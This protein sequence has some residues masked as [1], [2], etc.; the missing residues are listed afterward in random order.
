MVDTAQRL[1]NLSPAQRK[2][3]EKRLKDQP[4]MAQPIAVVGMACRLPGAPNLAA[5]WN[6]ISHQQSTIREVPP[7]RWDA[8]E[9]YDPDPD[10]PG[11][12]PTKWF[13]MVDEV[14]DFDP[15]FF[16]IS[17]REAARM[18]PQQRLLLEVTWEALENANIAPERVAGS[19]TGVFVGIGGTDYSKVATQLPNYFELMDPHV[20]TGNALSIAAN[21]ISY[22]FDLKGPSFAVDTAC[23]SGSVGLHLAVQ[24]LRNHECD[25]ALSGAVNLILTPEVSIAFSKARMLSPTGQCRPFDAEANGYVRGEGGI[26]LV[27]KRL[28]DATRDGDNILAVI[29]GT[30]INQDGRTSGITAPNALSQQA[31]IRA[32]LASAGLSLDDVSYVEAHGTGTPLGDPIEFQSLS[33]LF[34][35]RDSNAPKCYVGS[36]KANIGHT[37]TV[38][39]LAG[40]VKTILMM[41]HRTIPGQALLENLNPN[42][43]LSNT[44]LEIPR[45]N[46]DWD[47]SGKMV[48]GV[49]SFGFGGTNAHIVVE[50]AAVPVSETP[51]DGDG[52]AEG[53]RLQTRPADVLCLSAKTDS[54]VRQLASEYAD[55]LA[56]LSPAEYRSF[57]H[58]ANVGRSHFNRRVAMVTHS[59]EELLQQLRGVA[60]GKKPAGTKAAEVKIAMKPKVGFLFTG[61]GAQYA[62]M[63]KS[64][65][66]QHPVF[67]EQLDRCNEILLG[68]RDQSLLSVI[69]PAG[70]DTGL[71]NETEY[72]QPA[73]FAIEYALAV[74]WRSWG[75]E[76]SV[77]LGHSVG[78]YVAA[79]IAGVFSLEDG[80]RLIAKRA[81]LMQTLPR[82]GSMA[83]IFARREQVEEAI[84]KYGTRVAVATANGPENNVISGETELVNEVVAAFAKQGIGTQQL[85]V[86]HAFHSPL[87]DPILDQFEAFAS[88]LTYD[89]PRIPIVS[90]RTGQLVETAEFDAAYWRDHLRNAVEFAQGM[91]TLSQQTLHALIEIGPTASLL[92]MGKRCTPDWEIAWIPS[93][94]KGRND[95]DTLLS[96][97]TDIYLLGWKIDWK[98]F[99]ASW[100]VGHAQLPTYPFERIRCWYDVSSP[101][102]SGFGGARGPSIHPLLG[103]RVVTAREG[104]L[105]E[106]RFSSDSPKYLKD[107]QVQGSVVVPAAAYIEQG[108]AVARMLFGEGAHGVQNLSIQH[109][110]FLPV[111]GHRIVEVTATPEMSGQSTFETFSIP[112]DTENPNVRWELHASGAAVHQDAQPALEQADLDLHSFEDRV[113]KRQTR[114]EFYELMSAR[115]LA[116]GP[117]F[118]V[119]GS[120]DRS[121][122]DALS[123]VQLPEFVERELDKY[124]L[125][126]SLG[127]AML[128]T[129]AGIVP[130]EENGDYT[131][132]TYMP[133]GVRSVHVLKPLASTMR[134]YAIRTSTVSTPSPEMVEG[135]LYLIDDE[136]QIVVA[137]TGVSVRRVGRHVGAAG[138]E[139]IEDWLYRI[140]WNKSPLDV[141]TSNTAVSGNYLLLA[142]Q[143]G[144]AQSLA[145]QLGAAGGKCVVVRHGAE[146]AGDAAT[147]FTVNPTCN[148]QIA[149]LLQQALGS[150]SPECAGIIHC[151]SLDAATA[152]DASYDWRAARDLTTAS[153]L[154]WLQQAAKYPFKQPPAVWLVTQGAQPV[155]AQPAALGFA[156]SPVWG[157]GRVAAMEH[158]ELKCRLVDLDP[159]ADIASQ[160]G[161][162]TQLLV[163]K[164][165]EDQIAVR[166]DEYFVGRLSPAPEHAGSG[167]AEGGGV[168]SEGP[169]RLR[170]TDTGSFDSLKYESFKRPA[171]GPGQVEIEVAATGLNFSD[172]LKAMGLYPGITDVVV[173]VG[174]ECSG[175]VTAVG[176]GVDR[177][178]VGDAVMGVAP[179]SFASHTVTA[180]Y[181]LVKKPDTID[182]QEAATVPITFLTAYYGLVRLAQMQPGE[183]V[184]I[185]AGAGGVGLAAIQI[186]QHLGA[187]VFATAGSD[188]KR[189]YL[190]SLGVKHVMNS[191]N[192]EFADQIRELTHREGIDI[193][194]NS[195]PGEA[196][197]KSLSVLRAYGRFLEIGK[198]DIY[199]N[200]MIGLLPFQDNLSYFAIDLDRMLRQRPTYIRD[201]FEEVMQFFAA[202]HFKALPFT[203]FSA[204][205]TV[206]AFRYMAQRKNI[207]KVVVSYE[208]CQASATAAGA[209][210]QT[211]IAVADGTYLITGGLGALGLQ[212]AEWLADHGAGAIALL[213]RRAPSGD[214][215]AMIASL[216]E[217]GVKTLAIQ[218]DVTE[219]NSLDSALKQ[220]PADYPPLRGVFHAAGVLQDGVLYDMD[221]DQ[222]DKPLGP[223]VQG[224]WN[225]HVA[226]QQAP[227]DHFV[228][229]SSIACVLGSPGQANYAA[230][231]AFLDTFAAY[232]RA[233]GL[234]ATSINWGPWADSGMAAEAGRDAQL[235]SRGMSLLPSA[236]AL[237]AMEALLKAGRTQTAVMSVRWADLFRAG[238]GVIPPLLR[239]IADQFADATAG[240]DNA[241]DERLRADLAAMTVEQRKEKLDRYFAEQLGAIM[242]MEADSIDVTQPLGTMGLDSLMAIELKNKIEKKLKIVMPMSV[243]MQEPSVGSL[244]SHVA[245]TYDQA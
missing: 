186:A 49:S 89:R 18:D 139:N 175:T 134:C 50:A 22:I 127:D 92:G 113:I 174:I 120:I 64:L 183:R 98:A 195:L 144:V 232:R 76:P 68:E 218:G 14:G 63:A 169:F 132:Y 121:D 12:M 194:L 93:L 30:A 13:G 84:A 229:F 8:E 203:Q 168:P 91:E 155:G 19:A 67:R 239:D 234:P 111:E 207:G 38:S 1:A 7:D 52:T 31:C 11:K 3:L 221:L 145:E 70:T 62:G 60:E 45:K 51:A 162:L 230:A 124:H 157:L 5:Y 69:Y 216:N 106:G 9:F 181:A 147:G 59:H 4:Q 164:P 39:G 166:G 46:R 137:M 231:N 94:R 100:Q 32:A 241:E 20:G 74:L 237:D 205:E 224:T 135:N 188:D 215:A 56:E 140:D 210:T 96:A 104:S 143:H 189:D 196:I 54:A 201:L 36:V 53:N 90:N 178:Q 170:I 177:F 171:P 110:M 150:E 192:T 220:I 193:V 142:D 180:E 122:Y 29:R 114:E 227:L 85:T 182:H 235:A 82:N 187:E 2:L 101:G 6:V 161:S 131:P 225:L 202:G 160:A 243:F 57:C 117:G 152:T 97:L 103:A 72:T 34:A 42:I 83:V 66:E 138:G 58:S 198:T 108:L 102:S 228:L 129:V 115:G 87:M 86:S 41:Q 173:P 153:A 233:Q 149:Q 133:V 179:Y 80:L 35:S 81:Q 95:W 78:E 33:K 130:L 190:R 28:T 244:A 206:E 40:L 47:V 37:E 10:A 105:A 21:R 154:R 172:I 208:G 75:V 204:G 118:Q 25:T 167:A 107:H 48:A 65:Y 116:Y 219:A 43:E 148:E 136:N 61:Q 112:G 158:P 17:P 236:Q 222:L 109:A 55:T 73:L 214:A 71:L 197:P 151:W 77:L 146:L 27:L 79:C 165:A 200:T 163:T 185:H 159:A 191:R 226:T 238:T 217:R 184:L 209:G 24:A 199:S 141:D 16:G 125:H 176:E 242:G 128:Q 240:A 15:M 213:A 223:K 123:V 126:P 44:R 119:L 23:S 88:Q 99:D 212:V 26:M 156:Q 211:D 245:N